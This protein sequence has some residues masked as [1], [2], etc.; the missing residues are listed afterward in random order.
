MTMKM[1][2][3]WKSYDGDRAYSAFS[4]YI[5]DAPC[6]CILFSSYLISFA[7]TFLIFVQDNGNFI[8]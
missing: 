4:M 2:Q 8:F 6:M 1:I 3:L 7:G 5:I